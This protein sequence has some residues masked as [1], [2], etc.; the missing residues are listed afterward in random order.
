MLCS[1]C[2][3]AHV[4]KYMSD[5]ESFERC[6]DGGKVPQ[7]LDNLVVKVDCKYYRSNITYRDD[8]KQNNCIVNL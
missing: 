8:I 5:T 2:G 3:N 6:F 7:H 1:N 4:C